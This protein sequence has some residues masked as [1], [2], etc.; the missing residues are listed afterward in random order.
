MRGLV[1]G[2]SRTRPAEILYVED[3]LADVELWRDALGE[4]GQC[5]IRH[6]QDGTRALEYLRRASRSHDVAPPDL[7]LLDLSLPGLDGHAVLAAIKA[8]PT[9]R[10]IPVVVLSASGLPEEIARAYT[11]GANA[12][13]IKP[14][15]LAKFRAL[16]RA[17]H[18]FWC[19]IAVSPTLVHR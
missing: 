2:L 4:R 11:L 7:I 17:V 10:L 3:S 5:S 15:E 13:V 18:D 8:D 14:A 19:D 9:L 16:V 6:V 1:G 12:Y